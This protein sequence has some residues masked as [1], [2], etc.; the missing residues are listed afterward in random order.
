MNKVVRQ[1]REMETIES[2]LHSAIAGLL[3]I[4]SDDVILAQY[5]T[6]FIY[7]DKNIFIP[8]DEN[9]VVLEKTEE[10][11]TATFNIIRSDG[12]IKNTDGSPKTYYRYISIKLDGIIKIADDAKTISEFNSSYLKKY[13]KGAETVKVKKLYIIDTEEFQAIEETCVQS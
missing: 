3:S 5:P 12:K 11:K 2:E 6:T 1:I 7:L 10:E 8:A 4:H 9:D 13:T